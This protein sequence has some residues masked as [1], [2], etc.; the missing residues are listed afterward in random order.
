MFMRYSLQSQAKQSEILTI[1]MTD[2]VFGR[3]LQFCLTQKEWSASKLA[4]KT[5]M[6]HSY[7][8]AL[9]RGGR[10]S[11]KQAPKL[12]VDTLIQLSKALS[13]PEENLLLAYKGI[14]PVEEIE[15]PSEDFDF[16][17]E[18]MLSAVRQGR[19]LK[20]LS[21]KD[22]QKLIESVATMTRRFIDITVENEFRRLT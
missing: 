15:Q 19:E 13:V 7:I 1:M 2:W 16:T 22:R 10:S 6:S 17:R 5:G 4:K 18:V 14:D 12:S 21:K 11:D 9:I 8:G 20:D 3:Y